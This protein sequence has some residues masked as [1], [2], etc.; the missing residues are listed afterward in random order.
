MLFGECD[1]GKI[2]IRNYKSPKSNFWNIWSNTKTHTK[3]QDLNSS[4]SAINPKWNTIH[5]KKGWFI[6]NYKAIKWMSA[7]IEGFLNLFLDTIT[8]LFKC[9]TKTMILKWPFQSISIQ[10][11]TFKCTNI[12]L[13]LT[14]Q[15]E[16]IFRLLFFI[17][18]YKSNRVLKKRKKESYYCQIWSGVSF[19]I[20]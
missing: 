10:L 15:T 20:Y 1:N 13:S 12:F 2:S 5:Y 8:C 14:G 3:Y 7:F 17:Y 18:L 16:E 9:S 11:L 19:L 6:F 4:Y